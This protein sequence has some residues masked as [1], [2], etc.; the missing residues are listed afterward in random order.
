VRT[1]SISATK[2]LFYVVTKPGGG[3]VY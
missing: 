2:S 1:I 3:F